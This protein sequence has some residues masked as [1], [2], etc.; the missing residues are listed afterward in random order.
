MDAAPVMPTNA[1]GTAPRNRKNPAKPKGDNKQPSQSSAPAKGSGSTK[2]RGLPKDSPEV[3]MSK[4]LSWLLRHGAQSEGLPMRPDGFVKVTDLLAN[5][6]VVPLDHAQLQEMVKADAKQR[7][8]LIEEESVWWIRANQ[9]HSMKAVKELELKPILS[10]SDI[11]TKIAVHGT[12]NAAWDLIAAQGLSKMKRNHIHLAQGIANENVVSGMRKS[13]QILI[14][15][16]I[17]RALVDGIK[18]SLS[19]NGVILTEGD[20]RGILPTKYFTRVETAK[21]IPIPGWEGVALE[22]TTTR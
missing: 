2:L 9:G 6:R 1:L 20:E 11:P 15:V 17:E 18:F 22:P 3:R 5:P 13:S 12:T 4:T 16:D 21:R 19:D 8:A 10:I 7:F 14:F